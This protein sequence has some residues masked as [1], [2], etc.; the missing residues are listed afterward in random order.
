MSFL[1]PPCTFSVPS[2]Y[3][4]CA[5][6]VPSP[7]S[8]PVL[9]LCPLCAVPVP[10]LCPLC[11]LPVPS[12]CP[13][14]ALPLPLPMPLPCALPVPFLCLLCALWSLSCSEN[15]SLWL[16]KQ[17]LLSVA[18]GCVLGHSRSVQAP[19]KA[20]LSPQRHCEMAELYQGIK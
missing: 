8:F 13:S 18:H 11:A 9:S 5:L 14:C 6:S 4:L 20:L 12:L 3:L 2:L 17:Q 7:C 1:C 16:S 10:S 15:P 19:S